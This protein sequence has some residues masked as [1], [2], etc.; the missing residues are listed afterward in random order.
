[1]SEEATRMQDLASEFSQNFPGVILPD[2]TAGGGGDPLPH[3]PQ[4]G[5][6]PDAG[7]KRPGVGAQTLVPLNFSAVLAPR[8]VN[9]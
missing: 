7:H 8:L 6:W 4:P 9:G 1:M 5:L 3:S 2:P